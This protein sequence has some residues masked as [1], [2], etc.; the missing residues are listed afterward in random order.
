MLQNSGLA[1]EYL[2]LEL[3]ESTL[4]DTS[5]SKQNLQRME[6]LGVRIAIDDFGTGYSS[7]SYLKQYSVDLLK[8]DRTFIKDIN[9][10]RDNDAITSAVVAL[11][12]KLGMKVL[13]EGVET[14]EQFEF[15]KKSN[16]NLAQG[17]L[18][19][20][21]MVMHQFKDWMAKHLD[22]DT[23]SAYWYHAENAPETLD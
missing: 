16:C 6:R 7:L 8:I 20:R 9:K 12:H 21:P 3:T 5:V 2:E 22:K 1:P 15:L 18:I 13:A 17:F 11:S 4:I 19:G 23:N 10:D 14:L